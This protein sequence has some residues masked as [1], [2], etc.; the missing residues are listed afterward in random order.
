MRPLNRLSEVRERWSRPSVL[1]NGL[2]AD[3]V[4]RISR[5]YPGGISPEDYDRVIGAILGVVEADLAL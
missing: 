2:R 5:R 3:L 1:A 4:R